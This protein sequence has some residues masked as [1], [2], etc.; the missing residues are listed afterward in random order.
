MFIERMTMK[1]IMDVLMYYYMCCVW[2]CVYI[3]NTNFA[4]L[5]MYIHDIFLVL[6][7]LLSRAGLEGGSLYMCSARAVRRGGP[8]C[9]RR[10][11]CQQPQRQRTEQDP[12]SL[13]ELWREAA[14]ITGGVR[15]NRQVSVPGSRQRG[16]PVCR[17]SRLVQ[18]FR[19]F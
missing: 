14:D 3:P 15:G 10:S 2:V 16:L 5:H 9:G 7:N 6:R 1:E 18:S 13:P 17:C 4:T 19:H 8:V 11:S 12:V